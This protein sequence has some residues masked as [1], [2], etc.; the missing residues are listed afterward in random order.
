MTA[1]D[2]TCARCGPAARQTYAVLTFG[3]GCDR[4][5]LG[6]ECTND[7]CLAEQRAEDRADQKRRDDEAMARAIE[8]GVIL[9]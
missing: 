3:N 7:E 9:P 6:I 1:P 5:P 8:R 2:L 4:M